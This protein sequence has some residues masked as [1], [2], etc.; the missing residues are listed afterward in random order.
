M[1]VW[2]SINFV[3]I[4]FKEGGLSANAGLQRALHLIYNITTKTKLTRAI[5]KNVQMCRSNLQIN[6]ITAK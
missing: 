5:G 2:T 1:G 3:F 6:K 4:S